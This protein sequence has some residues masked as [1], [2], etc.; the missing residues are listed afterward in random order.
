MIE[1][2]L[3]DILSANVFKNGQ[4]EENFIGHLFYLDYEKANLLVSDAWKH[5]VGG[6]PQGAF[7][8]AFYKGEPN[9]KEVLLL[10][11]L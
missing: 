8:L 3:N 4:D 2:K 5:K 9:V 11:A 1:Q 7:L 6:I 10:R